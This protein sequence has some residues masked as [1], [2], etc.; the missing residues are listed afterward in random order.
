MHEHLVTGL[1]MAA[2]GGG[3][4]F[5]PQGSLPT[6]FKAASF[7][8]TMVTEPGIHAQAKHEHTFNLR[9]GTNGATVVGSG[10]ISQE[11][12]NVLGGGS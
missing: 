8:M 6:N 12:R 1:D 7:Y 3:L 9:G 5:Q 4:K 2:D 10:F 11:S